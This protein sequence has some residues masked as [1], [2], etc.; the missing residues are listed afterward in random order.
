MVSAA[1]SRTSFFRDT[2]P[3]IVWE[4]VVEHPFTLANKGV[5]QQ[6]SQP[7]YPQSEQQRPRAA[8]PGG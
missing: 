8:G 4:L 7:V 6:P 5:W 2:F 1:V 3:P